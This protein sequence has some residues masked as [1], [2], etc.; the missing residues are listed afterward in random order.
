MKILKSG[1]SII[2]TAV[3]LSLLS[4]FMISNVVN[5]YDGVKIFSSGEF[6]AITGNVVSDGVSS[7]QVKGLSSALASVMFGLI[8]VTALVVVTSV[9]KNA[10]TRIRE[11]KETDADEIIEKAENAILLGEHAKAYQLYG[12]M[13]ESYSLMEDD[14]KQ[15]HHPRMMKIYDALS[16]HSNATEASFL[17]E[18]YVNGEASQDEVERLQNIVVN[19]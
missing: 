8:A 15:E 6:A 19:H 3:L 12:V 16:R 14:E 10:V 11:S 18:K 17:T 9:G 13:R 5:G 2:V 4:T 1:R 7:D